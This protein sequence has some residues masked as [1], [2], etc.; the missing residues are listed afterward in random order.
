MKSRITSAIVCLALAAGSLK[1]QGHLQYFGYD[2]GADNTA[3]LTQ[4]Y[5][6]TNINAIH[7]DCQTSTSPNHDPYECG[8]C[9]SIPSFVNTI[10]AMN[11]KGVKAVLGLS[12]VL[13][14][15]DKTVTP[16]R[17]KLR[18]DYQTSW[19]SFQA[20]NPGIF[21]TTHLASLYI[22][23]EPTH[24]G[25]TF[26][27]LNSATSL[28]KGTYSTIPTSMVEAFV[29]VNSLSIPSTMDWIGI[30]EYGVSAPATDNTYQAALQTLKTK[31]TASQ[32]L[33][34]VMD[35]YYNTSEH[36]GWTP[37]QLSCVASRWYSL[38]ANDPAAVLLAAFLWPGPNGSVTLPQS[39]RDLQ[40]VAGGAVTGKSLVETMFTSQS[41]D[42]NLTGPPAY[43]DGTQ[44]SVS[45][46][47]T[48]N[49][50]R[51]Y[52]ADG[53]TGTHVGRIWDDATGAQLASVT[54]T[55]ETASGWQTQALTTPLA[56]VANK[57]YRVSYNFNTHLAKKVSG[58]Q[59][60]ISNG[61]LTAYSGCYTT[62]A[63]N[64]PST[65]SVGNY[66][67]DVLF[68]PNS[69]PSYNCTASYQGYHDTDS[70]AGISGW[71]WDSNPLNP[72]IS[73]D[74]YNNGVLL[75]SQV[76]ANQFRQDLLNAG[77]GNGYH[78]FAYAI[79]AS[80]LDGQ[81]HLIRA[82]IANT[83]TDLAWTPRWITC[84]GAHASFHGSPS[85]IPGTIQAEDYD[86]GGEG[87]GYHDTDT[88][89]Q[90]GQYRSD[91]VD[92]QTCSDGAGCY[93]VGFTQPGEWLLYTVSV[94]TAGTYTLNVRVA[95][96]GAG[97]TFHVEFNGTNK[98]GTLTI[99]NTG[100][101][102]TWQTVTKTVTLDAGFQVM[103][104]VMDSNGATGF[105]GN[106]NSL[107][108]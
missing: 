73:V 33:I 81:P 102:D 53:E 86:T 49:A 69:L 76:P 89:N 68:H 47:G 80:L 10:N 52:K 63:G 74:L 8:Y 42:S 93:N 11:A 78:T 26:S 98:T 85:G 23:D 58:L 91:G 83:Q 62:P 92:V 77:I 38:A 37:D 96:A 19:S 50:I 25:V 3:D 55:G 1:A 90:G 17:W 61:V 16:N 65:M 5:S 2:D 54:F 20:A 12:E 21:D 13:F 40:A 51:F 107:A 66:F 64:F 84:G 44:F 71:A 103:K 41:P 29:S 82:K 18:P 59:G 97:G 72:P 60:A 79:P 4:T 22:M 35:A 46:A 28:V 70:C 94:P 34:Y 99:P 57:N 43:E 105:V 67:A 6:Y 15:L 101:W 87:N 27:E 108:F 14:C 45:Q 104:L 39:A 30:D 31:V 48:I 95:S 88:V 32:K 36:V 75:K 9:A 106:F 100:G 56:I 24:N 7:A